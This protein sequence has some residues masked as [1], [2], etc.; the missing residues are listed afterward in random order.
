MKVIRKAFSQER[1]DEL[2]VNV[3]IDGDDAVIETA[4]PPKPE[5]W[6]TSDR[7]GTVEYLINVPQHCTITKAEL[8]N[9]E[10]MID[11]MRGPSVDAQVG[12]RTHP[13]AQLLHRG[14][15]HARA[16]RHGSVLRL[17]GAA[18]VFAFG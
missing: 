3:A 12:E 7:S 5:G 17:V 14:A 10:I 4:F 13:C 6:S 8:A 9:G 2:K 1:L 11:G 16:W 15:V 18:R